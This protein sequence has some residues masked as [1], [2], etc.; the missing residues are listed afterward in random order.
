VRLATHYN[1]IALLAA[2]DALPYNRQ[3]PGLDG[4]KIQVRYTASLAESAPY[5]FA[6]ANRVDV[7]D[8]SA[9]VLSIGDTTTLWVESDQTL[10]HIRSRSGEAQI[11]TVEP[12]AAA[13]W[14]ERLLRKA[15]MEQ[16]LAEGDGA[17]LRAAAC[18]IGG[19]GVVIAGP[20]SS[21]KTSVLLTAMSYLGAELVADDRLLLRPGPGGLIGHPWPDTLHLPR[22]ILSILPELHRLDP[23]LAFADTPR[24]SESIDGTLQVRPSTLGVIVQRRP[25]AWIRPQLILFPSL[26]LDAA[27]VPDPKWL[28]SAVIGPPLR[29]S[30][31]FSNDTSSQMSDLM[32]FPGFPSTQSVTPETPARI[33]TLLTSHGS[34]AQIAVARSP[35]LLATHISELLRQLRINSPGD[36]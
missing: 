31:L 6:G 15:I 29:A 9:R 30:G 32:H 14:A 34:A 19:T 13:R 35:Q 1:D 22:R 8:E 4:W 24:W 10:L 3:P 17:W 25:T 12:R 20:A 18:V 28:R 26:M 16:L 21:G 11:Y 36:R 33:L 23:E 5:A 2:L 7:L 27:T